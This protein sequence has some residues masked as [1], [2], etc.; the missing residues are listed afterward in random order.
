MTTSPRSLARLRARP[1]LDADEAAALGLGLKSL[2][3][4]LLRQRKTPTYAGFLGQLGTFIKTLKT[5]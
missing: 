4:V 2:G 5:S 3:W 1:E